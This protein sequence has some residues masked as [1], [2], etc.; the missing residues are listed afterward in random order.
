MP[1]I[2]VRCDE[3]LSVDLLY[4]VNI[5][6]DLRLKA[7]ASGMKSISIQFKLTFLVNTK[8]RSEKIV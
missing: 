6:L 3:K 2:I 1:C 4:G 8:T 5:D 7:L